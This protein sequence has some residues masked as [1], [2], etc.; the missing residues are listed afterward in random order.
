[1]RG[2]LMNKFEYEVI[3][4]VYKEILNGKN[5]IDFIS[6]NPDINNSS[7]LDNLKI[8][9]MD[10]TDIKPPFTKLSIKILEDSGVVEDLHAQNREDL[11]SLTPFIRT[12]HVKMITLKDL[13]FLVEIYSPNEPK[14]KEVTNNFYGEIKNSQIMQ[15][16]NNSKQELNITDS[17]QLDE[18]IR[19]IF[20]Y[21]GDVMFN[22]S[23]DKK[24]FMDLVRRLDTQQPIKE[25]N[26]ILRGIKKILVNAITNVASSGIF[27]LLNSL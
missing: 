18:I 12:Y 26:Q 1:M 19:Q 17:K 14:A 10:N 7:K 23:E 22:V 25:S 13:M 20:K 4:R 3:K 2:V 27:L 6:N 5:G 8:I 21:S 9:L 24:E 16:S 15:N 11:M